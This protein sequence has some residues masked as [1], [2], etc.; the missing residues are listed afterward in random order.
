MQKLESVT[1]ATVSDDLEVKS[2]QNCHD[3]T[4]DNMT[5]SSVPETEAKADDIRG[6][7]VQSSSPCDAM[8]ER[9]R[10]LPHHAETSNI[11]LYESL[12]VNDAP[13]V[14]T[15]DRDH[16]SQDVDSSSTI[17]GNNKMKNADGLSRDLCQSNQESTISEDAERAKNSSSG[18][19][20]GTKPADVAKPSSTTIITTTAP[21][22]RKVIVTMGK[23]SSTSSTSLIPK[24]SASESCVS[25]NDHNHDI[26]SL[27]RGKS[28]N[29]LISKREATSFNAARDEEGHEN[30]KKVVKE[31]P[32]S[33]VGSA[34]KA[35]VTK[36]TYASSSKRTLSD[37]KDSMP[38]SSHRTISVRNASANSGSGESS[39]SLQSEGASSVQN[40]PSGTILHQKGEKVNQSGSQ[41][42]VKV[43]GSLMHPPTLSSSPAALSDEEVGKTNASS[44]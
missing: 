42:S 15:E 34:S 21:S 40:K 41:P 44:H 8:L 25:S 38:H 23:S 36:I 29:N 28:D 20:H 5:C 39:S 2:L 18:L 33:S 12:K 43:S 6:D 35:Q 24:P 11:L 37:S 9:T 16:K 4:G 19:K 3:L 13:V 10:S 30:P 26:N 27:Q 32:K 31:I 1:T 14:N 7:F 22:Q 17:L